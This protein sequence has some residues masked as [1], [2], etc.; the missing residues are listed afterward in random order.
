M[1]VWYASLISQSDL[2]QEI[3]QES[4]AKCFV[5]AERW[6]RLYLVNLIPQGERKEEMIDL[7]KCE[8]VDGKEARNDPFLFGRSSPLVITIDGD[9][10]S[11]LVP[12][13][14][15]MDILN[16]VWKYEDLSR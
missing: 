15:M 5:L 10:Q 16:T 8:R 7:K 12:Y 3:A 14:I 6:A 2:R 1:Y 11:V 9:T 4:Q 13:G